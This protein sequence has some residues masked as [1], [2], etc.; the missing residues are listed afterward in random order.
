MVKPDV[1]RMHEDMPI[2]AAQLQKQSMRPPPNLDPLG[3]WR[4]P[5]IPVRFQVLP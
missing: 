3:G 5:I 1:T 4:T 2:K